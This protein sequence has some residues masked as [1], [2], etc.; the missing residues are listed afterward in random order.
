MAIA[1]LETEM[2]FMVSL[3]FETHLNWAL[4]AKARDVSHMRK[5]LPSDVVEKGPARD[6]TPRG[7][8]VTFDPTTDRGGPH[9]CRDWLKENEIDY[10][11]NG[12]YAVRP[13]GV[14]IEREFLGAVFRFRDEHDAFHFH[15]AF[16]GVM[17]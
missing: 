4:L 9:R 17:V 16:G 1:S 2:E 3:I 8:R 6:E 13:Q 11:M 15:L 5:L 14:S 7:R 12:R 10:K